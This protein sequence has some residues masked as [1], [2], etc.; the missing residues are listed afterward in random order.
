MWEMKTELPLPVLDTSC[1]NILLLFQSF[2]RHNDDFP[3]TSH[4]SQIGLRSYLSL[5]LNPVL[6]SEPKILRLVL[7][8]ISECVLCIIIKSLSTWKHLAN[9]DE[10]VRSWHFLLH[11][12][13]SSWPR[14][15]P[16]RG[17]M[18]AW[19][20]GPRTTSVEDLDNFPMNKWATI[21]IQSLISRNCVFL[22]WNL[23]RNY[24]VCT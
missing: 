11:L 22:L 1:C 10:Q 4:P 20:T 23:P 12:I 6:Q 13:P 16:S 7:R 19:F 2:F 14:Q 17:I 21:I 3:M 24:V 15:L 8:E 18:T 5:S 9:T